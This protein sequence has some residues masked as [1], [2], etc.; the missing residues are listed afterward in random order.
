MTQQEFWLESLQGLDVAGT[1]VWSRAE[2]LAVSVRGTKENSGKEGRQREGTAEPDTLT[3][4]A[5]GLWRGRRF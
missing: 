3:E 5:G 2:P 4:V 1:G